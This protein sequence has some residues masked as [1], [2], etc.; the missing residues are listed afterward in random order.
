MSIKFVVGGIEHSGTTLVSDLFRQVPGVDSGFEVGVLMKES[1][2]EFRSFD[3]FIGHMNEGWGLTDSDLDVICDTDSFDEF[4]DRLRAHADEID[5]DAVLFD[6]TPRYLKRLDEVLD[7]SGVPAVMTFK[8]PRSIVASD[9]KRSKTDDFDG[10]YAEYYGPK[11]HYMKSL[12]RN[13]ENHRDDS[14]VAFASLEQISINTEATLK[15]IFDHVGLTFEHRY[16]LFKDLKFQNTLSNFIDMTV[17]FKYLNV[18]TEEQQDRIVEDFSFCPD[19][20][21]T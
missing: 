20:I 7:R 18:L 9:F 14:R 15:R 2:R 17:P 21:Y 11:A 16:L 12:Y 5:D 19:W 6:K 8:D 1:P 13:Y 10:W 4:Y 3:P